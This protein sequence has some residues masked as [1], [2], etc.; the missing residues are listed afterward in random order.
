MSFASPS[1]L[2]T[3]RKFLFEVI[4]NKYKYQVGPVKI[5]I[6][7]QP[8]LEFSGDDIHK[9]ERIVNSPDIGITIVQ[10]GYSHFRHLLPV[11]I[12]NEICK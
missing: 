2:L 8:F 4:T 11:L 6:S 5:T 1:P 10:R 3:S 7:H 9:K 12:R